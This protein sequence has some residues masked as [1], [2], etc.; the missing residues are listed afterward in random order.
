MVQLVLISR[1][2]REQVLLDAFCKWETENTGNLS[3]VFKAVPKIDG[4][5]RTEPAGKAPKILV[6]F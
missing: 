2:K 4:K 1:V 6:T 5:A 3:D